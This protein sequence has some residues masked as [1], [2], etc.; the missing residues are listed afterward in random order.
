MP[1]PSQVMAGAGRP[2]LLTGAPGE[3]LPASAG[4][5]WGHSSPAAPAEPLPP[6]PLRLSVWLHMSARAKPVSLHVH[7]SLGARA[8]FSMW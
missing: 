1:T 7:G 6:A 2:L 3:A 5:R 4:E 8:R